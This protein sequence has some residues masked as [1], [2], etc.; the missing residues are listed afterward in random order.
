[1]SVS[2]VY[3]SG[4]GNTQVMAE[5]VA[6][7]I[8]LAGAEANVLE[9]A[10]ADAAALASEDA[11][12]LGCPSMGAEQLEETEMEPFVE[13]LEPL[14]SGKKILLFGSYGWGDGEWMRDWA[15]RMKNAGAVLVRAEGVIANE[16]P[17]NEALEECRAAGKDLAAGA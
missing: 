8:R 9:V 5:A 6:E 16:A 10:D 4:T 11:F 13:T 12:A 3:W 15:D 14:V 7:G 1:M 17:D 2:V